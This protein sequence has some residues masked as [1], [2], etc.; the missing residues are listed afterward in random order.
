MTYISQTDKISKRAFRL[1]LFIKVIENAFI[2]CK[3]KPCSAGKYQLKNI[4]KPTAFKNIIFL[5]FSTSDSFYCASFCKSFNNS[6][7]LP[8]SNNLIIL[9]STILTAAAS[10]GGCCQFI[11]FYSFK[12][13]LIN[14]LLMFIIMTNQQNINSGLNCC[15]PHFTKTIHTC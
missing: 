4:V 8:A 10:N 14:L 2:Q 15:N 9:F 7:C 3:P 1:K 5:S 13:T 12:Y 6:C 11:C